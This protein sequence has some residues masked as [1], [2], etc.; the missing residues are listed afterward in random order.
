MHYKHVEAKQFQYYHITK[1]E[2][3]NLKLY[4]FLLLPQ[5]CR[6]SAIKS[7]KTRIVNFNLINYLTF[8]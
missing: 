4:L 2:L 8:I 7:I 1:I 3:L 5:F 6:V